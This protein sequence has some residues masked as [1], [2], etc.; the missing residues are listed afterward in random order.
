MPEPAHQFVHRVAAAGYGW[1][2]AET[3]AVESHA[4]RWLTPREPGRNAR[5][6]APLA[7]HSGLC[8]ILAATEPSE[9]G[10][11]A[12][13]DSFGLLGMGTEMIQIQRT[14]TGSAVGIGEPL[15]AWQ[16]QIGYL[17]SVIELWEHAVAGDVERLSE[18]ILWAP[19]GT[20][21]AFDTHAATPI[22]TDG[23]PLGWGRETIWNRRPHGPP[24]EALKPGD[25]VRPALTWVAQTINRFL[26]D[27]VATELRWNAERTALKL[28]LMPRNLAG[29]AWLQLASAVERNVQFRQCAECGTWFE[30]SPGVGRTNKLFHSAA[31]RTR[32]YRRRQAEAHRLLSIGIG[33]EEI[34]RE[35]D[36]DPETLRGWLA[37]PLRNVVRTR[38][39]RLPR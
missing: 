25:L 29:A 31:C 4:G 3:A 26:K 5:T 21:V 9:A 35:L 15:S 10:V 16:Q 34:A 2:D 8:R 12:F 32:A 17:R 23:P 1:I 6:Y 33:E 19:D 30:V 27:E 36:V 20:W 39:R 14:A 18:H 22:G 28:Q 37:Q 13:A 11:R 38:V 7:E 24:E